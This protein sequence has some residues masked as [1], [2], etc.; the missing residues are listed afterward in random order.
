LEAIRLASL[1][2]ME[3]GGSLG[4]GPPAAATLV[5]QVPVE[6]ATAEVE[7]QAATRQLNQEV[8]AAAGAIIR[9]QQ[10]PA[11]SEGSSAD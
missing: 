7:L 4:P 5:V 8:A 10:G 6:A 2:E 11:R 3:T 9:Q 1:S